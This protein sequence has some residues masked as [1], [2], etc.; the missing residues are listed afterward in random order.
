MG[1]NG[2]LVRSTAVRLLVCVLFLCPVVQAQ[3][4]AKK[5]EPPLVTNVSDKKW[6]LRAVDVDTRLAD[7]YCIELRAGPLKGG[8]LLRADG[9]RPVGKPIPLAFDVTEDVVVYA[10]PDGQRGAWRAQPPHG[11]HVEIGLT[12]LK[13]ERRTLV[14]TGRRFAKGRVSLEFMPSADRPMQPFF[15]VQAV[16]RLEE[17]LQRAKT[18]RH[19][20]VPR[21]TQ[22]PIRVDG[23]LAEKEWADAGELALY[24]PA[25]A[26]S[27][28]TG[29]RAPKQPTRL[30]VQGGQDRLYIAGRCYKADVK[31]I[32]ATFTEPS[33]ALWKDECVE[34]FFRPDVHSRRIVQIILTAKGLFYLNDR[35]AV[36]TESTIVHV[37]AAI[38]D[39]RWE[40]EAEL[41][42]GQMLGSRQDAVVF[43]ATRT[44]YHANGK[45]KERSG[46]GTVGWNDVGNYGLLLIPQ[47][48]NVGAETV[49]DQ[50][51]STLVVAA[52]EKTRKQRRW[53]SLRRKLRNHPSMVY[54]K[55]DPN[56]PNVLLVG[57]SISMGYTIPVRRL[58][59]GKANLFRIPANGGP[60]SR[61]LGQCEK[62]LGNEKWDVIHFNFGLHDC[63][64]QKWDVKTG[65]RAYT[66]L[67]Y[68]ENLEKVVARLEQTGAKLIWAHT[69]PIPEGAGGNMPGDELPLNQIAQE[70]MTRHNI[71]INDLHAYVLPDLEMHQGKRNIHFTAS[72]SEHLAK[73]IAAEIAKALVE[74]SARE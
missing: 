55:V 24:L 23:V 57:D 56:L 71:P 52:Q 9:D 4:Q 51:L 31:D 54:P 69:T 27:K 63:R 13:D 34:L 15:I 28:K 25:K 3:K 32:R 67:Q 58:L 64:Y 44:T 47:T 39:D 10:V 17:R 26:R 41:P 49:L 8:V 62:W 73:K 60:T 30:L 45:S 18:K 1:R 66:D 46:W 38:R 43:N 70:I 59:E 36:A 21:T 20:T 61:F 42:L 11:T 74:S 33:D 6:G 19:C 53:E 72:G 16:A 14:L 48:P 22:A 35:S 65:K 7:L 29:K 50:H 40:F 5:K 37:A 2:H 12:S 68:R